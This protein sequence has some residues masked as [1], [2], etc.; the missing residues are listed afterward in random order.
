[1]EKCYQYLIVSVPEAL[2]L[3]S[4]SRRLADGLTSHP[5]CGVCSPWAQL[6]LLTA[7]LPIAES[8]GFANELLKKTSGAGTTPQLAFSH[9][10]VSLGTGN[11]SSPVPVRR[12]GGSLGGVG[13]HRPP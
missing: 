8:F 6:F 4:L 3:P 12:A 2:Y 5:T 7:L 9:W 13:L 10:E 11:N 1:M